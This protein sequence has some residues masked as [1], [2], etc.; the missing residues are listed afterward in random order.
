MHYIPNIDSIPI[1]KAKEIFYDEVIDKIK[2][3]YGNVK[4]KYH[5]KINRTGNDSIIVDILNQNNE[6]RKRHFFS[7]DTIMNSI[8]EKEFV[9]FIGDS[10]YIYKKMESQRY[11]YIESKKT[12]HNSTYSKWPSIGHLENE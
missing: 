8:A 7:T 1:N 5:W 4:N 10:V 2:V 11:M 9:S 3:T 12:L 6:L